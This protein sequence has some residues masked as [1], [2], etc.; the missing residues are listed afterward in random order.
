MGYVRLAINN[1]I[2]ILMLFIVVL[3]LIQKLSIEQEKYPLLICNTFF[4]LIGIIET[5]VYL[6]AFN[7]VIISFYQLLLIKKTQKK[8]DN[9]NFIRGNLKC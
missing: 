1:G 4:I 5:Y 8:C 7:F 9:I 6:V 3:T 2:L